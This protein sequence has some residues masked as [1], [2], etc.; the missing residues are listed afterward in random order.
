MDFNA[1]RAYRLHPK[2]A[3]RPEPFGALAYHYDNRRLSFLRAPE[4]VDLV[5]SLADHVSVRRAFEA[6]DIDPGRWPAFESALASLVE[7]EV[8]VTV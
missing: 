5:E 4:L 1:D 6:T 2:V 8:L 7:S 3:I